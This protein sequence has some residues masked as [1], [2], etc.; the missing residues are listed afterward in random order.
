MDYGFRGSEHSLKPDVGS[1]VRLLHR[2]VDLGVNLID[3]ARSY[4]S[5]EEVI[6]MALAEMPRRPYIASKVLVKPGEVSNL[7]GRDIQNIIQ[8]SVEASLKTLRIETLD[9]LQIH[10]TTFEILRND[11]ILKSLEQ[12]KQEGKVRFLGASVTNE[13]VALEVLANPLFQ[14]LQVAFNVLDQKMGERVFPEAAKQGVGVLVRSAFLRGV[15]TP[16]LE[17]IPAKLAPLKERVHAVLS[18]LEMKTTDLARIALRFCLSN[19]LA[20]SVIIGVRSTA[21]LEENLT[22]AGE[23]PF[24]DQT[25]QTLRAFSI[26]NEEL[27]NPTRWRDFILG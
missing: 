4:G 19:S 12:V 5:S 10:Q 26:V 3:T 14:T 9:I 16:Q 6:G 22:A 15:L 7:S 13:E 20:S 11:S 8:N 2:V 18:A 24:T 17:E 25:L 1:A 23:G 21:E 27:V